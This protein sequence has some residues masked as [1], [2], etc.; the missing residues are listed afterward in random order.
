MGELFQA[1]DEGVGVFGTTHADAQVVGEP[2]VSDG[3]HEDAFLLEMALH[4]SRFS[5]AHA[6]Q[7]EVGSGRVRL[8]EV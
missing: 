3:T 2:L 5:P 8:Q 6:A 7:Q 1:G 4:H